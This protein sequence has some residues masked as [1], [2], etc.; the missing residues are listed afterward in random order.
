MFQKRRAEMPARPR[1]V[2]PLFFLITCSTFAY[3][4][5]VGSLI[6]ILPRYATGPLAGGDASVGVIIGAFAVAAVVLRPFVGRISDRRGRRILMVGGAGIVAASTAGYVFADSLAELVALRALTGA[7]E[8]GFYVG[9]AT[10]INDIAPD[11]RRGEALSFFSLALFAGL[12][13]GPVIGET[14]LGEQSFAAVWLVS[15]A[16]AALAAVFGLWVTD[17]R[18]EIEPSNKGIP[19][20]HPAGLLPGAALG[21][22]ICGLAG[23]DSFVPLYALDLGLGGSRLVFVVFSAVVL[24]IRS[25]G[26]R[27]PDLLGRQRM[28][29]AGLTCTALGLTLIGV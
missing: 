21:T 20:I 8:A 10:V 12:A 9:A 27:L 25:F 16:S 28:A 18:P 15:A 26:A 29:S 19:L 13:V 22:I 2:T 6:P 5:S 23:F 14:V 4:V 17:T 1:L 7:G 3:F 11:E 24:L